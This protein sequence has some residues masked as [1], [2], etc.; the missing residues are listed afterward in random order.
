MGQ[1]NLKQI[2]FSGYATTGEEIISFNPNNDKFYRKGKEL[3]NPEVWDIFAIFLAQKISKIKQLQMEI[4][5]NRSD[6][7]MSCGWKGAFYEVEDLFSP[8]QHPTRLNEY[9]APCTKDEGEDVSD[10]R[11]YFIYLPT[12]ENKN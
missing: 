7:C 4:A 5:Y 6:G 9:H 3:S 1:N 2:S 11:G 12:N 8:T 10:H